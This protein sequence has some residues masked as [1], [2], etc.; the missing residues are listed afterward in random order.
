MADKLKEIPGKLLEWW[1]KYTSK[2][3]T[4]IIG[5]VAVVIFTFVIIVYAF[6]RPQYT[7]LGTYEN[8]STAAKIVAILEDAGI[9]DRKSVV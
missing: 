8:T 9:T 6:S 7:R 4:I 2:Q 3:K 5:I 1:N